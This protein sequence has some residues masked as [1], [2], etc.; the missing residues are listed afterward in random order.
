DW[1]GLLNAAHVAWRKALAEAAGTSPQRV[2]VQT[3]HQHNAPFAC[4]DAERIVARHADLPHIVDVDFFKQ[5]LEKA[6]R[7]V[8]D[9]LKQGQQDEP[10]CHHLY[11]TGCAGNIAAGK[12]NDGAKENRPVLTRRVYD[13]IVESEKALKPE[14]IGEVSW[15]PEELFLPP[16]ADLNEKDLEARI[17]DPK[18]KVNQ[19]NRP[20]Y[21]LAWLLRTQAKTPIV[22]SAL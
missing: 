6:R 10:G 22:L 3:V 21:D 11:F 20:S 16:R 9:S 1:T 19:R 18:N 17:A 7:S 4:L 12:Y 15:K 5:C 2:A 8:A 14:P 13:G